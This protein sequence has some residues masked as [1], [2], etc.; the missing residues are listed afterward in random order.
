MRFKTYNNFDIN[1]MVKF[2]QQHQKQL[3]EEKYKEL[4]TID[5]EEDFSQDS[6]PTPEEQEK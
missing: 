3:E 2:T 6:E 1:D 4:K 5:W